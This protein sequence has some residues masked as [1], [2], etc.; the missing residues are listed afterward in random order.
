MKI[1]DCESIESTYKSLRAILGISK[2]R[3]QRFFDDLDVYKSYSWQDGPKFLLS[4]IQE[5]TSC[6]IDFDATCWFHCT[7][8]RPSNAFEEGILPLNQAI[9]KILDFLFELCGDELTIDQFQFETTLMNALRSVDTYNA[10]VS[11]PYANGG[12]N[13]LLIR[14]AAIEAAK[15]SK[16]SWYVNY[17]RI[18]EIVED[19]CKCC[20]CGINLSYK[21]ITS[22]A[23]CIVKFIDDRADIGPLSRAMIYAYNKYRNHNLLPASN[24]CFSAKGIS[25]PKDRILKV[26]FM[27][28]DINSD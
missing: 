20:P 19:I 10:R 21:F 1:L 2:G 18:P 17:F 28:E 12:P 27:P 23:P 15:D 16:D 26:E 13:A 14:E 25:V 8:T 6:G 5:N 22:T 4:Y 24:C 7:R 11:S 3:L 9:P